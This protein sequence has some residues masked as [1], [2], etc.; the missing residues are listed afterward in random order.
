[1][2]FRELT[3]N[4]FSAFALKNKYHNFIQSAQT[5]EVNDALHERTYLF[6][7][8]KNGEIIAATYIVSKRMMKFF[9]KFY[10]PNG[11]LM[12]YSDLE[13][14]TFFTKK[15]C[16]FAKKQ[17]AL[18]IRIDPFVI[19]EE[20]DHDDVATIQKDGQIAVE[21]IKAAGYIHNGFIKG[22]GLS[23]QA[24]W[25]YVLKVEGKTY[26]ETF[27][28]FKQNTRNR[29]SAAKRFQTRVVEGRYEDL[30]E[31]YQIVQHTASR[32]SFSNRG[33]EYY[34]VFYK[35]FVEQGMAKLLFAEV[36]LEAYGKQL[37]IE[38]EKYTN[39]I[40]R[41][42][43]RNM[44]ENKII[45]LERTLTSFEKRLVENQQLIVKYG[46]TAYT[47]AALFVLYGDQVSYFTSGGYDDFMRY[48]GQYFLQDYMIRYVIDHGFKI[49]NFFGI[50]GEFENDGVYEFKKGFSGNVVNYIGQFDYIVQPFW[51]RIYNL[52]SK[53]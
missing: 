52:L 51:Y 1:M 36:D 48:S 4:E 13:C 27:K 12:D 18:I 32:Q 37:E 30:E 3:V 42:K 10:A 22:Y 14:I 43:S 33:L 45:E 39:N 26:E 9:T 35:T 20:F 6:G 11:F 29:I 41:A 16:Q 5:K 8:L 49:Y 28:N 15:L 40:E 25:H 23:E 44:A 38:I 53:K 2:E 7:V 31:F 50:T 47:A 21:N 17:N 34:Q 46:N 24:R 19:Y